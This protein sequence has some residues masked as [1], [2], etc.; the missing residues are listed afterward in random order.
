MGTCMEKI[1]GKILVRRR[2]RR[3]IV[4]ETPSTGAGRILPT[5]LKDFGQN[6]KTFWSKSLR[7]LVKILKH[8]GQN[9]K[10]FW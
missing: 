5:L 9:P 1:K 8:F 7:I 10:G 3:Q 2:I 4:L 6:L